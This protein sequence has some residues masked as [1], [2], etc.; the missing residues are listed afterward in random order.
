MYRETRRQ[1]SDYLDFDMALNKGLKLLKTD[2]KKFKLGFLIVLGINV[3]LRISDI[4]KLRHSDFQGDVIKL[5]EKKTGKFREIKIN[6]HVRSA[7]EIYKTKVRILDQEDFLFLSKVTKVYSVRHINREL[8]VVFDMRGKAVSTHSL[9]K[10]F[11]RAVWEKDGCS[12]RALILLSM[13]F[14]HSSTQVTRT[15]L[16]IQQEELMD[17]YDSL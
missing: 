7:Y 8:K 14:N 4:L 15:Y 16:G 5:H 3:G 12:E 1:T 13:I 2:K 6:E 9:R 17:V 11:G 10:T